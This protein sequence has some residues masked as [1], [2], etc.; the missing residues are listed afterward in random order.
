MVLEIMGEMLNNIL[1]IKSEY[2]RNS[3]Y[4][5]MDSSDVKSPMWQYTEM[6]ENM[7]TLSLQIYPEDQPAVLAQWL[8]VN[9]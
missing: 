8:N 6:E 2:S 7:P 1:I 9:P 5:E 4:E 3:M